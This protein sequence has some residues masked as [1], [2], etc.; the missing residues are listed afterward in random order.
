M[1]SQGR[2]KGCCFHWGQ[3]VLRKVNN[4]GLKTTYERREG[5]H[6]YVR[7]LMALGIHIIPSFRALKIVAGTKP[8]KD[9]VAY[10]DRTWMQ[11]LVAH[12]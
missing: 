3:A 11:L 10:L 7:K 8:L 12:L 2:N 4:L 9:L 1:F 5:V 6:Q